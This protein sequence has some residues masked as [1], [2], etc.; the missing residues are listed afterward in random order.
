MLACFTLSY[1]GL[2]LLSLVRARHIKAL[3][4]NIQPLSAIQKNCLKLLGFLL[5]AAS[6]ATA[7]AIKGFALGSVYIFAGL[8]LAALIQALLFAYQAKLTIA[9]AMV[10]LL[11]AAATKVIG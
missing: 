11:G 10:L 2:L 9:I 5:L 3:A 6:S 1:C 7:F 4:K 8:T